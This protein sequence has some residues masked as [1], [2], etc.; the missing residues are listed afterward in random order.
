MPRNVRSKKYLDCRVM[1]YAYDSLKI[2]GEAVDS[3]RAV[4]VPSG[5]ETQKRLWPSSWMSYDTHLQLCVRNT[6]NILGCWLVK[7]T[8]G[9]E[10]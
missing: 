10:L 2:R 8:K 7:P 9:M 3:A 5:S 1:E 6:A 4:Y